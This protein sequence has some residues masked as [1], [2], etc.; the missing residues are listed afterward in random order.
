MFIYEYML[1]ISTCVY[2][3]ICICIYI[4]MH[5]YIY[6][7]TYIYIYIYIYLYTYIGDSSGPVLGGR[8]AKM[9]EDDFKKLVSQGIMYYEREERDLNMLLFSESLEH[10]AQIDRI[11][12]SNNGHMLLVGRSGVGRRNA[13]TI[14]SYMLGYEFYTPAIPRYIYMYICI[15]IYRYIC[16]FIYK[17]I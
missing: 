5:I 4:F 16:I 17:H 3:F 12:T 10:I 8:L 2:L 11:L 13:V 15:Y 9:S 14:A 1:Y 6:A 7:Y